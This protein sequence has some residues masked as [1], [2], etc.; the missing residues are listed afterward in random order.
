MSPFEAL[1]NAIIAALQGNADIAAIVEA[2]IYDEIPRDARGDPSDA[3]APYIYLGVLE[4]RR[5][6]IGCHRSYDV[7]LAIHAVSTGFGRADIWRLHDA[8]VP[9]LDLAE[10]TLAG[11][12]A[13][14][15]LRCTAGGDTPAL[16][17]PKEVTV[18]LQTLLSDA[19]P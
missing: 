13:A 17:A 12:H 14:T 10:L 3:I 8:I 4:W 2:K 7:S 1:R 16:A 6:E 19:N 9:A 5:A 15:P 11:G 18:L